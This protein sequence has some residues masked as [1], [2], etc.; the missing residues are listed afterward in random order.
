ML[1]Q[2]NTLIHTAA[3]LWVR[4]QRKGFKPN[5]ASFV[6]VLKHFGPKKIR[7]HILFRTFN[8]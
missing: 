6:T 8:T 4:W 7:E 1:T 5:Q 3:Y 2:L